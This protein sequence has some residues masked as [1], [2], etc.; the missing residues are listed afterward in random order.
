[1]AIYRHR[2]VAVMGGG[3]IAVVTVADRLSD[4]FADPGWGLCYP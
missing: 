3:A 4:I 2:I 1:M